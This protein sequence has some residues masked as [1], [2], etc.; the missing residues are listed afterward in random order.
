[1]E[2][3]YY[4]LTYD[5]TPPARSTHTEPADKIVNDGTYRTRAISED[6]SKAVA[7][8]ELE[9]QYPGM[10]VQI[11]TSKLDG[12]TG[13][14]G[15]IG[16]T[17]TR[18]PGSPRRLSYGNPFIELIQGDITNITTDVVVNA[19]NK[20]L[21][22]GAGVCGAIYKAAGLEK[23]DEET[24]KL[25]PCSTGSAVAS[26]S[27]DLKE[28]IG[29]EYIIH[30]V[31]PI[32]RDGL[33]GEDILLKSVYDKCY[34]LLTRLDVCHNGIPVSISFP[35]I[36]TGVYG[37]PLED[38]TRIAIRAALDFYNQ[39]GSIPDLRRITT[40]FVC[41]SDKDFEMYKHILDEEF[42]ITI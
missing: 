27:Y 22:A 38:A 14:V 12:A 18:T 11:K 28:R 20:E 8:T 36:S 9:G 25:G 41:F 21:R 2:I 34:D 31:G 15:H 16:I 42:L 23:L 32:Y 39:R 40:K 6:A 35:A 33:G 13:V 10:C 5:V 24:K 37:F 19:A 3:Y 1:M 30:A 26:S 29:A 7:K 17:G 4:V